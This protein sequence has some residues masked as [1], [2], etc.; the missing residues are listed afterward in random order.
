IFRSGNLQ[1]VISIDPFT[2]E[3]TEVL[4]GPG[5]VI[6]GSDAIGGVMNFYTLT[7]ELSMEQKP[8]VSGNAAI[9]YSSANNEYTGHF[10]LNAGW[11][12]WASL[13]SFSQF[14][15][16]DLRIG[17][18]GPDEYLRHSYVQRVDTADRV[19]TNDHPR[20]QKPTGYSQTN[21]MQKIRFAPNENWKITYG[22]HYSTTSDY[23]RYDRLLRMRGGLP[24]SAEWYYG[25]QVWMMNNLTATHHISSGIYDE[26]TTRLAHQFFKESRIDR[27]L[28]DPER[29]TRLEKV[30]AFSANIDF[31]KSAGTGHHLFYGLEAV[32][33][34]VHS[35]GTDE[36]IYTGTIT[37]GPSRYPRSGWSS[38]AAYLT[39][40]YRLTKHLLLQTGTRYN[41][42]VLNAEFDTTFYPFPFT[43]TKINNGALTGS[44]G[45]IYNPSENWSVN[46][47]ISTGFRSPNVDDIGKVFD[48]EPGSVVVPNPDLKAEYAWNAEAG[49]VRIF[50][51]W[52]RLDLSG[53][54]T[55]LDNALVRRDFRMNGLDSIMYDGELSKVQAIQNAAKA[56]VWGI[57]VGLEAKLP[58]GFGVLSRFNYQKGE[59]ELD[60]GST[61]P[62]RH[63]APWFNITH[64]TYSSHKLMLDLYTIINAEVSYE[65]LP[66]EEQGKDYI[67]AADNNGNPYCPA[68]YT[69]SFK[70]MYQVTDQLT[71]SG[72]IE[73]I[74][75]QRYRPYSSGIAGPGRNFIL[76]FRVAF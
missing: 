61:N 38:L 43:T 1:N 30:N 8:L 44:L 13:T 62:L 27:D 35:T 69:L 48:S 31:N 50:N 46:A 21:L 76:A 2:T 49:I 29:R 54:Y 14:H 28:N 56:Y 47:N 60:D 26:L 25:P 45:L 39:W 75:N 7:P 67:Y 23:D 34:D 24:R 11:K 33:N 65:N 10:S 17:S 64:F 59:E 51:D 63:A 68:W 36:D 12:K 72:G 55:L 5:S 74:T 22:F 15:F 53:F 40:Q 58:K 9:R 19:F 57:Q 37:P 20:I 32:Y 4:F 42:F 16:D 6:Y 18:N 3:R 66:Q 73:N 70:A 71:L 41:H 52:L